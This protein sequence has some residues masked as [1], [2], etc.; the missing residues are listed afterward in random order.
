MNSNM[1]TKALQG[2]RPPSWPAAVRSR[3]S[4]AATCR[5]VWSGP[6]TRFTLDRAKLVARALRRT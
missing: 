5:A 1:A 2:R 3:I 4:L 6:A